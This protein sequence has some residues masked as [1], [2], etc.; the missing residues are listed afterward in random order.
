VGDGS[1]AR[2]GAAA[3]LRVGH[4]SHQNER[5]LTRLKPCPSGS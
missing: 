4:C 5:Y 2:A 3:E 1:A